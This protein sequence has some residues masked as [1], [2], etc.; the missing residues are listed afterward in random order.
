MN[1]HRFLGPHLRLVGMALLWGA[2]WPAGRIVAQS[3]PPLAA[4]SLRFLLAAAVLLPWL[5]WAGGMQG[6]R[7][8]SA[9]R[10]AGMAVA[11][12][13]GVFGYAAFFLMGL[14]H[15]PAG[16]AALVI[17]LNPVLTLALAVWL[18]RERLNRTIGL[19]MALAAC[20]AVVVIS[21]GQ[22]LRLLEGSVGL[23]ELLILG[24]VA[25]WVSYTLIGRWLLTGVDA[26]STTA[27]T[28]TMGA[29]M[30][31]VASLAVEG[32]A[33]LQAAVQGSG[34]AWGALLFLAFGAT[35]LAY[36]WYFDGVKALGA[37]A[38]SGY[39]TL[40]PVIGVLLSALWLGERIDASI[41]LGGGMAVAGT[42]LM[43][44][45]RRPA[46]AAPAMAQRAV[47]RG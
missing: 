17:T 35:A 19:G 32:S 37:G 41:V 2:S 4:A 22:P 18:F 44:W 14:Q 10:W 23:G 34:Q 31:L 47:A 42:A 46:P 16:K 13:T 26:L 40:V 12:A 45:G 9:R 6:L 20:G 28:S 30:L 29:L 43:N 25:C 36:A 3:L 21:H 24:C 11:A 39:I 7:D 5:Y 1:P 15:V 27:V 33:G 38:A 8:W